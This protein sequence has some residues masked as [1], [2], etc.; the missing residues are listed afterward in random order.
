MNESNGIVTRWFTGPALWLIFVAALLA[1]WVVM[2]P[3]ALVN[4][5][6]QDGYSPFE[7]ATLPF[8]AAIV[9]LVWWKC[10]FSGSRKRRVILCMA[11]SVVALMAIVKELDLH[12]MALHAL[13]PDYV[14]EDG[15]L[16]PGVLFKPNGDPLT[17]TPFKA[18]FLTN[19]A[20][21]FGAKAFVVLYFSAF[22]GVFA[23]GMLYFAIPFVKGVFALDPVAWSYGCFGASGVLVQIADR[24]P[25]WLGHAHGLEKSAEGVTAAQSL[26]TALEE[27]GEMMIAI[28]ALLAIYQSW[29]INGRSL[30]A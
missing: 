3:G 13:C 6:D 16:I 5:F 12:N 2:E 11:V 18:R 25:S 24:L 8:F 4:A 7:L 15:K 19:G 28:F 20:V 9:P 22:F 30:Q 21:P 14:G 10:P 29:R 26:C 17:G 23:A 27:G 1:T